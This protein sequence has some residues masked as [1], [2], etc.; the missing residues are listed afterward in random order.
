MDET[1][2]K[3]IRNGFYAWVIISVISFGF[4][5]YDFITGYEEFSGINLIW[6]VLGAIIA[7]LP[8]FLLIFAISLIV[9]YF[10]RNK[11]KK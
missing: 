6:T 5:I 8:F 4:G 2:S 11:S 7:S 9:F 10:K 1:L 3:S